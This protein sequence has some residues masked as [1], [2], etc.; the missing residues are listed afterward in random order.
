MGGLVNWWSGSTP[1]HA[2]PK[3]GRAFLLNSGQVVS[4]ELTH[5][6]KMQV[7]SNSTANVDTNKNDDSGE[8]HHSTVAVEG[9]EEKKQ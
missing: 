4:T 9:E 1:A 3:A 2:S 7:E 8:S 5:K 6:Y